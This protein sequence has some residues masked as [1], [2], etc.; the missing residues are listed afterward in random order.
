MFIRNMVTTVSARVTVLGL[1]LISSILLARLLGPDGRGLLALV[2]IL[3]GLAESFGALGLH[4]ANTVFAGLERSKVPH[5]LWHSVGIAT[6]VGTVL[7]IAA[8]TYILL[9]APGFESLIRGPLWLYIL[10][11]CAI[12]VVLLKMY[13]LSVL[14]GINRIGTFN[15]IVV[16]QKLVSVALIVA[17]I[18]GMRLGVGGAVWSNVLVEA[19]AVAA[20]AIVFTWLGELT[21]PA[22]DLSLLG[23]TRTFAV[24]AYAANLT[25]YLNYRLDQIVIAFFLDP[26]QL[27]FYVI[28]VGLVERIWIINE[29]V[30]IV[31]LPRLT[32][33]DRP[34]PVLTA[35]VARHVFVWTGLACVILFVLAGV[36]VRLLYSSAFAAAVSPLRW[37][38]PGVLTLSVGKVLVAELLVRK[39]PHL[40]LIT[41]IVSTSLNLAANVVLVPRFGIAGAA[42]AS[43]I[44]YSVASLLLVRYYLRETEVPWT[45]LIPRWADGRQ[46]LLLLRRVATQA[47]V[48]SRF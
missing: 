31:L 18:G 12:P 32:A 16:S 22:V 20:I 43:T 9:G 17:L 21:R 4:E 28:A 30:G 1:S 36:V 46:Y 35:E 39:K 19:G 25:Q 45:A 13:W 34:K 29:A 7:A 10:P 15:L 5:L 33:A 14:R 44:S 27:A 47:R 48:A 3:P 41:S 26:A 37:L 40:S 6:A 42:V 23:Q 8:T 24:P 11:L 38:L 2:L